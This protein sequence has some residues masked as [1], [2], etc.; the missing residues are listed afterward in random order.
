MLIWGLF[1][2]IVIVASPLYPHSRLSAGCVP[3]DFLLCPWGSIYFKGV[4]YFVKL[5]NM[6]PSIFVYH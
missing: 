6:F 1:L 3:V 4:S 2:H 5:Q